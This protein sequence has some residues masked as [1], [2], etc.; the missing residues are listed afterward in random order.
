MI[1]RIIGKSIGEIAFRQNYKEDTK[2]GEIVVAE[3]KRGMQYFF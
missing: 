1:G 2:I 3:I